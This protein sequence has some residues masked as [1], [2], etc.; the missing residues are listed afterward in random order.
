MKIKNLNKKGFTL[1]EL[2]AVIVILA[3]ILVIAVPSVLNIQKEAKQKTTRDEALMLL[4]SIEMCI[5]TEDNVTNCGNDDTIG[6]YY[7]KK[8]RMSSKDA[9]TN[10]S[11]GYYYTIS[12][13]A[14]ENAK[15]SNFKFSSNG[16]VITPN[17]T[18]V[19]IQTCKN[20]LSSANA[21]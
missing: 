8:G 19:T 18:D 14:S 2:L 6:K 13:N 3:I 7:E 16:Y 4:K 5:A 15:I 11:Y 21:Q 20:I 10:S 12:G 17:C 1:I 9:V